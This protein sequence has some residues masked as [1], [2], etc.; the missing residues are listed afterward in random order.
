MSRDGFSTRE[1]LQLTG[2]TARQLQWWDE[3]RI[4]VPD[5]DGRRRIYSSEDLVEIH[6]IEELR[7]RRIS[8]TTVRRVLKFLRRETS[9][10]LS[11]LASGKS[12]YH[13]LLDGKNLYLETDTR[14]IVNLIRNTIQPVFVICLSEAARRVEIAM[15]EHK[16]LSV[17]RNG[18]NSNKKRPA[19]EMGRMKKEANSRAG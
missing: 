11:D 4:I 19:S 15:P 16:E 8:L 17:T 10:R 14:Q 18:A 5:R 9:M 12:D 6:V 3:K 2:T 13:L 1:V 7:R